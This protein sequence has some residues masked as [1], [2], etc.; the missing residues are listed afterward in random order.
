MKK[1]LIFVGALL[2]VSS[3]IFAQQEHETHIAEVTIASK[4]KQQLYKT[5]KNVQL[6][7]AKDLEK[8]K[9][10]DLS[11]VLNQVAGFQIVGNHNNSQEPKAMKIR[12]GKS[13]NVLI[14]IDGIPMKDVT[15]NDYNVSDLRLMAVEHVESIEIL[16]GASSVLY[17]S[18]ATVSVINIK[19]KKSV[20]KNI[21][22]MVGARAGSF[23]TFA[24]NA[25]LKGKI[26]QFNYQISGFNEKSQGLSSADGAN[27][28]KDGFEKQNINLNFGY[29]A[30]HFNI[31]IHGGWN[32]HLFDYDGGAFTDGDYRSDDEQSYIGGNAKFK[33]NKGE[34][35]L[36]T[37]F[38]GNERLG[39]SL[40]NN[41][42]QDQFSYLGR[43][44]F[45]E[46]Y[47]HYTVSENISFTAGVQFENQKMGAESLPWGET[48][49]QE[50]LR[51]DETQLQ[52]FDAFANLN[53]KYN[54]IN[55]DAGARMTDNSKFGNHWVYSLN[56]Y[57]LKELETLYFKLGYSYS[58]AFIAPTLYQT[59]GSL[60]YVLPN[61]G[62]EPETNSSHEID[63]SLGKK[64]R[65]IVFNAS[66]FQREEENA[67]A[68]ET[69]DFITYA[70]QFK[71]V[72]ENKVKGFE[73]G[74]NYQLNDL[75]KLGGNFS[76]V[77]KEKQETMLRQP[78]QRVNSFIEILPFTSTRINFSHQFVSKRTDSFYNSETFSVENRELESFNLF[79][80]NVNQKISSNIE[81]YLNIGNLF[82]KS[83]V[84][85][86]G[87]TTKLRNFTL[88]VSYQF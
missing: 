15:G 82:N 75:F 1:R 22:G 69:V 46:L 44:S 59:Y 34:I 87:Y 26:N 72:G 47:N 80:L 65:S 18:N 45:S 68:Y 29:S 20:S 52:S 9:G 27:F 77:E 70:G 62:L 76:F 32:H 31:N 11:D 28:E 64:D 6:I 85:V 16:N 61:F 81:T 4:T 43:N 41:A 30:D 12:G 36:N 7:S 23:S 66:F 74:L 17:G 53:L 60:P 83:Y 78:K 42:Y 10:Q 14:L 39:Q 50:D 63:L 55:F 2:V 84:D 13:A 51:K 19:T 5:G 58:T 56:P 8:H 86:I 88:G 37:R 38:S 40:I 49:M 79:N 21:E 3:D 57:V 25:L 54:F 48:E 71:N 35:T 33:Y 73:L 24:Q 67:F